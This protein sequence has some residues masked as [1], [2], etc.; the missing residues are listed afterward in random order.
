[1][2]KN[3]VQF[4]AGY[5]LIELFKN[6]GTENQCI[7]ALFKWRWPSGF[8]CP[9]CGSDRYCV[10]K[11]RKLY[12]CNDCRHQTSLI[13][14]TIFE[15]TKLPLTTWFLAIHLITQ[16]K[17]GLSA[18]ALKRQIGVSYNTAWSMKHKIMQ[19]MKERDDS[20]PLSGIIQLDDVYWG[21]ERRGG[22]RGR[23]S[24]NKVPFVAAVSLNKEGHPIAMNMNVVKGF[25]LTE[26]SRWAKQHLQ[27]NS[28]IISD[29]LPCF[30]AVKEAGCRHISIVT[31][32]G[33]QSVTKE[34]FTW[35]NT[36]IG[37][38]KN[39]ITGTYHAINPKHLPRYLA[40]FC[41]RH[42][43]RVQLEDML[44]RFAYVAVRTPP[45]PGRLLKLA[46][47]YG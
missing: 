34:E 27:P 25:R 18:L 17:T 33:P 3:K 10:L 42:N 26:I 9:Q 14:G 30:S 24:A 22:K 31:G 4:Q 32:G 36:L 20:K 44:P 47:A 41:Y 15:Q 19:V 1:M 12:Q 39:A 21:G 28:T 6:Y 7:E 13:S 40:E 38:V 45:M 23:G 5:S 11:I 37:N 2:C 8:R 16:S 35:I 46:E 29:G 43:R